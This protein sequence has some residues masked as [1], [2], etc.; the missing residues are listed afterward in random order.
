MLSIH[1]VYEAVA[2]GM[3]VFK[4]NPGSINPVDILSK[5]WGQ[6]KMVLFWHGDMVD[7]ED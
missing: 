3:L 1:R 5:H 6:L 7:I 4:L 2:S